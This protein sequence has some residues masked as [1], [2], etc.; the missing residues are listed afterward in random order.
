MTQ[1]VEPTLKGQVDTRNIF[2]TCPNCGGEYYLICLNCR[3]AAFFTLEQEKAACDCGNVMTSVPCQCGSVIYGKRFG[4]QTDNAEIRQAAQE[5]GI[6]QINP[7][8]SLPAWGGI[9]ALCG[10]GLMVIAGI[11]WFG[12]DWLG[13]GRT[14]NPYTTSRSAAADSHA[15]YEKI[16][17][18]LFAFGVIAIIVGGALAQ[19]RPRQPESHPA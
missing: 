12:S 8:S 4:T 5:A 10:I 13:W 17:L 19:L 2:M 6:G 14:Y 11:M 1:E 16:E 3:K 18:W 7:I 9:L 15:L